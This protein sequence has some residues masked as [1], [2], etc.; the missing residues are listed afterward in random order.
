MLKFMRNLTFTWVMIA[1]T[2]A[3]SAQTL[4]VN[5]PVFDPGIPAKE[6][7]WKK[8]RIYPELRRAE[9]RYLAVKL[10]DTLA[11]SGEWGAVRVMPSKGA[12]SDLIVLATLGKSNGTDFS[13][14]ILVIDS[15]GKTF[16]KNKYAMKVSTYFYD[17]GRN[18]G[19]DPYQPLLSRIAKDMAAKKNKMK[20]KKV[21]GIKTVTQLRFAA[22]VAP[23]AFKGYLKT[24]GK[25]KKSYKVK[26]MPAANDPMMR[27][28]AMIR[29]RD[30]MF[31]DSMQM[32]FNNFANDMA[33]EYRNYR[34]QSAEEYRR[35]KRAKKKANKRMF[36]G[37][38]TA[39][40]GAYA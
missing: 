40:A 15:K 20:A 5:I 6:S 39:I 2:G 38:L 30:Q 3:A 22:D 16:L 9:A 31:V 18:N 8:K 4:D 36:L 26:S 34:E 13:L 29:L 25:K 24:S 32:N 35:E 10:A 23:A 17:S 11:N 33:D 28:I 37:A 27:R 19:K 14:N 21:Q 1:F 12:V 7:T